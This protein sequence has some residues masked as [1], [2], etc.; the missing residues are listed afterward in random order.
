M[1]NVIA[2]ASEAIHGAAGMKDGLLRCA[3]NDEEMQCRTQIR[4]PAARMRP[5]YT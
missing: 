5:G 4:V 1:R 2:S 3:R